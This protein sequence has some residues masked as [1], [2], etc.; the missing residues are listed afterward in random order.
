MH[1]QDENDLEIF[2]SFICRHVKMLW[3]QFF[4]IYI[5]L[6]LTWIL[7]LNYM[8][9]KLFIFSISNIKLIIFTGIKNK[10]FI[11]KIAHC[12]APLPFFSSHAHVH[13][14]QMVVLLSFW[15]SCSLGGSIMPLKH[16]GTQWYIW[17]TKYVV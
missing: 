14:N 9:A 2:P 16:E 8:K 5:N 6:I 7:I 17:W 1:K 13:P 4:C 3:N 10:W 12:L 15:P 11:C